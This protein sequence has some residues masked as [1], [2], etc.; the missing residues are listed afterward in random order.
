MPVVP[1]GNKQVG[2]YSAVVTTSAA[3]RL[4][5]QDYVT[6]AVTFDGVGKPVSPPFAASVGE[7][8]AVVTTTAADRLQLQDYVP[9]AIVQYVPPTVLQLEDM[10]QYSV[11]QT[12][13]TLPATAVTK[14]KQIG[15]Y[16]AVVTT[17][18]ADRLQLQ[19]MVVYAVVT[20]VD[21]RYLTVVFSN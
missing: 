21:P 8:S 6:Y 14:N 5:L 17:S 1:P 19:D 18:S 12:T 2:E 13:D 7:Y 20:R 4:Q 10:V 16:S 9:Y 15:E 3:D 11:V